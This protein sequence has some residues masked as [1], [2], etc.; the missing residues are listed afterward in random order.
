VEFQ[1]IQIIEESPSVNR[2]ILRSEFPFSTHYQPGQFLVLQHEFEGI[3]LVQRSYSIASVFPETQN[4]ELCIVKKENGIFSPWLFQQT[5]GTW[6][7]GSAPQGS[8]IF[9]PDTPGQKQVFIA[10]GT[11]VAP[12]RSMIHNALQLNNTPVYLIFGNRF[13]GDI[14]YH[15]YWQ[16]LAQD[17]QQFHYHPVLSREE[18]AFAHH[19]YVHD[20]YQH[21][22]QNETQ[23]QIYVCGWKEMLTE[24]RR[25]LKALG[26][27]RQQYHFEQYD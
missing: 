20:V 7:I 4:F 18:T 24:T 8:F 11:G 25:N 27:N 15:A 16:K 5:V 1:I 6:I 17:H 14:L 9:N 26:F 19:G 13:S 21:V 12:F 22:L 3:G 10:T 23:A 2:F